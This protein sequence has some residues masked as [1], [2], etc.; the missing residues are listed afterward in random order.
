MKPVRSVLIAG[1]VTAITMC[2]LATAPAQDVEL[3]I[4]QNTVEGSRL[5]VQGRISADNLWPGDR[6]NVE[7]ELR[8]LVEYIEPGGKFRVLPDAL[9]IGH[10]P[11]VGNNQLLT[12]GQQNGVKTHSEEIWSK[13]LQQGDTADSYQYAGNVD[14]DNAAKYRIVAELSH[15]WV[16]D[17]PHWT[18]AHREMTFEVPNNGDTPVQTPQIPTPQ[19]T[20][21]TPSAGGSSTSAGQW[22][23]V[24]RRY[25][26]S[27]GSDPAPGSPEYTDIQQQVQQVSEDE[28]SPGAQQQTIGQIISILNNSMSVTPGTHGIPEVLA[29][30]DGVFNSQIEPLNERML[31]GLILRNAARILPA[32]E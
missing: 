13:K 31:R 32:T 25:Y 22:A 23:A 29:I 30:N 14:I 26:T 21:G 16:D 20:Q 8:V 18:F 5:S 15:K 7:N 1:F 24:V 28:A 27:G 17:Q 10:G 19:A 4:A 2:C 3:T 12:A 11:V 6:Q 9:W